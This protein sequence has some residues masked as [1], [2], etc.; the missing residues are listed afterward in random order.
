MR[1]MIFSINQIF[2][3]ILAGIAQGA[4]VGPQHPLNLPWTKK[5]PS[6]LF[7]VHRWAVPTLFGTTVVNHSHAFLSLAT[8][9]L[10]SH[11]RR[12]EERGQPHPS[13]KTTRNTDSLHINV[14]LKLSEK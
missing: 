1:S 4:A 12:L 6:D 11:Q 8:S 3:S 7:N 2:Q 10:R 14:I 9:N 13:Y 5:A